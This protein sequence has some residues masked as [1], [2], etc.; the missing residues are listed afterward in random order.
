MTPTSQWK[1]RQFVCGAGALLLAP[2]LSAQAVD[3]AYPTKPVTLLVPFAAGG[4]TDILARIIAGGMSERLVQTVLVENK[5]GASTNIAAD[6][7]AKSRPDG[8]TL[9]LGNTNTFVVNS[10]LYKNLTYDAAKDLSLIGMAAA[11]P[12]VLV[13]PS[14]TPVNSVSEFLAFARNK[15]NLAY[16][17]PG[18]GSPH[19]LA[20]E[21][22]KR[23][24]GIPAVHV[25]YRGVSPAFVDLLSGRVHVMFVDYAAGSA[26]IKDGRLRAL[27]VASRKPSVLLPNLPTMAQ[28]GFPD[29]DLTGWQGLAMPVGAAPPVMAKLTQALRDTVADPAIQKRLR[30]T[31]LEPSY[32]GPSDFASHIAR[33]KVEIA[34]LVKTNGIRGE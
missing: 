14:S 6:K 23:H 21:M 1:R 16:A 10:L 20:M 31:G 25:A 22:L 26:L 30:D 17:T 34:A 19:H 29:F 13:V 7:V 32:L 3:E 11:F 12:M 24:A 4:G 27:A 28:S 15:A 9:L 18:V 2:N 5:P 8:Y 33:E